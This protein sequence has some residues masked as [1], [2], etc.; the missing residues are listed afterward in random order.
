MPSIKLWEQ[1][2]KDL[3]WLANSSH[4]S[5][6]IH[7]SKLHVSHNSTC[8]LKPYNIKGKTVTTNAVDSTA[9][10]LSVMIRQ[11]ISGL[12]RQCHLSGLLGKL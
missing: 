3:S 8:S 1:W 4:T 9:V 5:S 2:V 11:T 6:A 10:L 12:E 7:N